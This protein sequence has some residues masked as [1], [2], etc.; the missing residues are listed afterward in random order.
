MRG[1]RLVGTAAAQTVL[2]RRAV[3]VAKT[4]Y[5]GE[6][7]PPAVGVNAAVRAGSKEEVRKVCVWVDDVCVV[8]DIYYGVCVVCVLGVWCILCLKYVY[9]V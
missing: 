8:C 6:T 7:P 2:S 1:V 5:P 4:S 9:S 3:I